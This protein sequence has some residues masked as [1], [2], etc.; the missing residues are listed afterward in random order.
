MAEVAGGEAARPMVAHGGRRG[1][2]LEARRA[3]I[4]GEKMRLML[5]ITGR[6]DL[7]W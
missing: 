3:T 6:H 2:E 1:C 7:E 5:Q 4:A